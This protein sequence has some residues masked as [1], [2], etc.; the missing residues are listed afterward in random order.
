MIAPIP[1]RETGTDANVQVRGVSPRVL[2]RSTTTSRWSRDASSSRG[3]R[4][5]WS[6]KGAQHAY[7]GLDLGAT[8][9][10]GG[11]HLD[12]RRRLRRQGHRVRLRGL[13]DAKRARRLLQAAAPTCSSR[14]PSAC[15]SPDDFAAFKARS[16][17]T[18]GSTVQADRE[19]EYYEKQSQIVTTLIRVLGTLVAV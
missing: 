1:L 16:R 7:T 13:G 19:T 14:S 12:D 15:T 18:R 8:V 4:R 6:G 3:S 9:Q 2:S 5:R 17:A 10:I 11:G